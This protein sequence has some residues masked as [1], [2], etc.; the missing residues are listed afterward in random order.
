M[1]TLSGNAALWAIVQMSGLLAYLV[2]LM[3]CYF[4][5]FQRRGGG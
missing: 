5:I 3:G 1:R 2:W 4:K